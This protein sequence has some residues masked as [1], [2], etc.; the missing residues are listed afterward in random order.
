M[1]PFRTMDQNKRHQKVSTFVPEA[2]FSD[3]PDPLLS[4]QHSAADYFLRHPAVLQFV[5]GGERSIPKKTSRIG[6]GCIPPSCE[7]YPT[8]HGLPAA[9][10][11]DWRFGRPRGGRRGVPEALYRAFEGA[12]RADCD[13]HRVQ[14]YGPMWFHIKSLD[15]DARGCSN[16]LCWRRLRR[17]DGPVDRLP[18]AECAW[19]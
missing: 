5:N 19:V 3:G 16:P 12:G 6:H 4:L 14:W 11:N 9:P 7:P 18:T 2:H 10:T 8:A 15:E 1:R 13:G 17:Y